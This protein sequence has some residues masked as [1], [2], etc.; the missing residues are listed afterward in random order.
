MVFADG[1]MFPSLNGQSPA[2][3]VGSVEDDSHC[4]S[5]AQVCIPTAT[6]KSVPTA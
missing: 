5:F 1:L 4:M 3:S 6:L 2:P